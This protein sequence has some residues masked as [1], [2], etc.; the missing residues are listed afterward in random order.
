MELRIVKV[1]DLAVAAGKYVQRRRL[2]SFGIFALIIMVIG[3]AFGRENSQVVPTALA[4]NGTDS[5]DRGFGYH[6]KADSLVDMR[7]SSIQS[8]Q[9]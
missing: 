2:P 8:V 9:D 6:N 1:M 4:G 7:R 3:V 5:L